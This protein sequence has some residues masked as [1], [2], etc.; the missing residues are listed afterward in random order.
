MTLSVVVGEVVAVAK[1]TGLFT[2]TELVAEIIAV[3]KTV[4]VVG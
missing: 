3:Q 2:P 4:T 1:V